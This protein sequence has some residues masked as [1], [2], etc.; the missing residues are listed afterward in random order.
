MSRI[1]LLPLILLPALAAPAAD[2]C[3]LKLLVTDGQGTPLSVPVELLDSSGA[4]I[5]HAS[6]DQEGK[7]E[8][9]DLRFGNHSLVVGGDRCNSVIVRN[10]RYV[11]PEPR[12]V[13]VVLNFCIEAP[14]YDGTVCTFYFRLESEQGDPLPHVEMRPSDEGRTW[15]AD[16]YGRILKLLPYTKTATVSFSAPGYETRTVPVKCDNRSYHEQ[17]VKLKRQ[18]K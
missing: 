16:G 15:T 10:V 9:C 17:L 11:H 14:S 6:A 13:K 1:T 5:A 7:A 12:T 4:P 2:L 18:G 8:F 3:A